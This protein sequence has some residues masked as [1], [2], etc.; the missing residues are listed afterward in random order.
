[1]N[2]NATKTNDIK[3]SFAHS[4]RTKKGTKTMWIMRFGSN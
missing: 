3:E 4:K 2:S 1:M